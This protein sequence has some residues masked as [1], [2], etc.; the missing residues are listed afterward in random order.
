MKRILLAL[1][2]AFPSLASAQYYDGLPLASSVSQNDIFPVCQGGTAGRPGTCTT[3]RA[4]ISLIQ[5]GITSATPVTGNGVTNTLGAWVGYLAGLQNPNPVVFAGTVSGA[6]IASLLSPYAPLASPSLTGIPLAPTAT[7][8]TNTTQISTTAFTNAAVAVE[9]SRAETAEGLLLPSLGV[10]NGSNAAAGNI[11]EYISST[12]VIGS[13]VPLTTS[14][15]QEITSIPLTAGDWDVWGN[16]CYSVDPS[17][18]VDAAFGWTSTVVSTTFPVPPNNGAETGWV[19]TVT[20]VVPYLTVGAQRISIST[21]TT[22]YLFTDSNFTTSTLSACGF[23][24]ARR[25]R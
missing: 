19:G 4:P 9:T 5:S 23:I 22:V 18:V 6:G 10:T 11:G 20:G 16:I 12:V 1:F 15:V 3:R 8:G 14:V 7:P 17:T 21:P 24:G 13:A 2:L 25:V